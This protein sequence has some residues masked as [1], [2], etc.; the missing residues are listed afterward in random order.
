MPKLTGIIRD[1][2]DADPVASATVTLHLE[3]DDSL[4]DSTTTDAN[5]R[6]AFTVEP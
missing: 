6:Y 4:I 5:G 2:P 3:S 1:I